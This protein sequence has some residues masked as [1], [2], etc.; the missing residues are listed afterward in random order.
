MTTAA[1]ISGKE[2]RKT[3]RKGD[4]ASLQLALQQ[5]R[6]KDMNVNDSEGSSPALIAARDGHVQCISLLIA[7]GADIDVHSSDG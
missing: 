2:I 6:R 5:C 7:S 4:Y 1:S 3:C